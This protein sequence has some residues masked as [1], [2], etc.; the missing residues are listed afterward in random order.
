MYIGVYFFMSIKIKGKEYKV[1]D[2]FLPR[3][4]F[5]EVKKNIV[6]NYTIDWHYSKHVSTS[7]SKIYVA[8]R[9]KEKEQLWTWY[10]V[11]DVYRY[12][13]PKSDYF[14]PLYQAFVPK[15]EELDIFKALTRIK[16]NFYPYT[17]TVRE[18]EMHQDKDWHIKAGLFSLNTCDGY[19]KL[20][21]G[22]KIDSVENRMLIFD[23]SQLHCSTTTSN[24]EARYNINFNFL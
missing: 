12:S 7:E 10:M 4:E 18:H 23:A 2:N 8:S 1:I 3:I 24:T 5:Q 16:I 13:R 15:F 9:E 14:E 17:E 6:E 22:T 19:T 21:D 11:H 20:E